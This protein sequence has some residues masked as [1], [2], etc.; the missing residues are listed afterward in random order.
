MAGVKG[1]SGGHNRLPTHLHVVDGT[2]R[3][4]R[5]GVRADA[6]DVPA[7]EPPKAPAWLSR[8]GRRLY[9][10][11]GKLIISRG[12]MTDIDGHALAL[13][14]DAYAQY[15][16]ASEELA[17]RGILIEI[18]GKLVKNPAAAVVADTWRRAELGLSR[19]GLNPVAR[20]GIKIDTPRRA[21]SGLDRFRKPQPEEAQS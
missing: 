7:K 11:L 14:A 9:R 3:K 2:F 15:Q 16:R 10:E 1:R 4:D 20:A 21:A 6:D 17:E 8:E 18:D 13:A 12:I 19:F 5:H